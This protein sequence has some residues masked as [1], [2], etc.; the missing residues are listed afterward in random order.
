MA[1]R[2]PIRDPGSL[3]RPAEDG[4]PEPHHRVKPRQSRALRVDIM[5]TRRFALLHAVGTINGVTVPVLRVALQSF[6]QR[7]QRLVLDLREVGEIESAGLEFLTA[8]ADE[9]AAAG[10]QFRVV[11]QPGGPVEQTLRRSGLDQHLQIFHTTPA[12][13]AGRLADREENGG[14]MQE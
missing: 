12:A 3:H 14:A 5:E 9:L 6:R 11:V 1:I 13:L 10:G 2:L 7:R 8:V 4:L